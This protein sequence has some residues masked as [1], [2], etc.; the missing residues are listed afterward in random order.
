MYKPHGGKLV[1]R[2]V[3][4]K[5]KD[6]AQKESEELEKITLNSEQKSDVVTT[7]LIAP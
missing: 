2:V 1:E 5:K 7:V 6:E 3:D 4:K